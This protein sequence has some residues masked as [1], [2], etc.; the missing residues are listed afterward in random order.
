M[1]NN[2]LI[3]ATWCAPCKR[4]R[5]FLDN[6]GVDYTYVDIETAEGMALARGWGVR[7]VPSMSISG[8]IVSGDKEIMGAFSE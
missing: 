5:N 1:V 4:V 6:R 3:G 8:N 2:V 7:A